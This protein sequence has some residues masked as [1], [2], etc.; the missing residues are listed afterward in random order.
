MR[1]WFFNY[2]TGPLKEWHLQNGY[3]ELHHRH[4]E[5]ELA[6]NEG[7]LR[8]PRLV[9]AYCFLKEELQA[10]SLRRQT[11]TDHTVS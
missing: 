9:W 11:S 7:R 1:G 3:S 10:R 4:S 8:Q 5:D 2:V 6:R